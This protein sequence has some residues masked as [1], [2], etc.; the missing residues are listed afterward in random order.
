MNRNSC[1]MSRN[2]ILYWSYTRSLNDHSLPLCSPTW[3]QL[4]NLQCHV[5][6]IKSK[7][8]LCG[9]VIAGCRPDPQSSGPQSLSPIP[10]RSQVPWEPRRGSQDSPL[11]NQICFKMAVSDVLSKTQARLISDVG[12]LPCSDR[13]KLIVMSFPEM[14]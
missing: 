3:G 6:V 8:V 11:R 9:R 1:I 13:A 5:A 14:G 4:C 2:R 7:G 10:R 12:C